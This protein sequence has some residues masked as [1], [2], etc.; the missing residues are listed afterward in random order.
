MKTKLCKK[1]DHDLPLS[2]FASHP[3]KG[4]QYICK[5]CQR[6]VSKDWYA[7]NKAR[8]L[9]NNY[10]NTK[11]YVEAFNAWKKTLSCVVCS[12]S[13]TCCLDFH[14]VASNKKEFSLAG[15]VREKGFAATLKELKK[16]VCLCSNC[17]RK[18]H[19][20]VVILDKTYKLIDSSTVRNFLQ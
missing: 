5:V 7:R 17:H 6:E 12:E 9:Q 8:Q 19:S 3:T 14:H 16:C 11:R 13:E 4:L 1:C 2:E 18:V 20:G 10:R 15:A